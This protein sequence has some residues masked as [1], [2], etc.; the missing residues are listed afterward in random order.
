MEH[1]NGSGRET[2]DIE[3]IE[4]K[5]RKED[6]RRKLSH[7]AS[8][9]SEVLEDISKHTSRQNSISFAVSGNTRPEQGRAEDFFDVCI[10]IVSRRNQV[11]R[12]KYM[13]YT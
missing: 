1:S 12:I 6:T 2:L 11:I 4:E 3:S 9:R 10:I 8:Y 7:S 5:T 13:I